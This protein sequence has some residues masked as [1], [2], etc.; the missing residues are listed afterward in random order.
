MADAYVIEIRGRTAGIVARDSRD[1]SFN[2]F[3]AE[4]PFRAMEACQFAD[5][6]AA[7]RTARHVAKHG[8]LPRSLDKDPTLPILSS[9]KRA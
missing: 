5:P 7:E 9:A 1:H 4:Q 8:N 2:F 6:L 3:A